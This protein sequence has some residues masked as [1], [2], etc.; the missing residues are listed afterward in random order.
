MTAASKAPAYF[1]WNGSKRRL[2]PELSKE[3]GRYD[4][5]GTYYEP[6]VGGGSIS[7]WMRS[8]YPDVRQTVGDANIWLVAMYVWQIVG[9]PEEIDLSDV[10]VRY[11][12]ALVDASYDNLTPFQRALR[13]AVCLHSSWGHRWEAYESGAFRSTARLDW[14]QPDYLREKLLPMF[15]TRWLCP[16]DRVMTCKWSETVSLARPGDLVVLDPPYPELLGY[17]N[18][19]W[20]IDDL[21][22]VID[23][24]ATANQHGVK[25]VMTCV[26]DARRLLDRVGLTTRI[27]EARRRGSW[28]QRARSEMIASNL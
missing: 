2:I 19:V 23:W 22:D 14:S 5:Q 3:L 26:P 12:R 13:F 16:T 21:L 28:T 7:C 24:V 17:G 1:P 25:I 27:V 9:R 15:S 18:N 11:W 10:D 20:R 6:F 4:G 8:A